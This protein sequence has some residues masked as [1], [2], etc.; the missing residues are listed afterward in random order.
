[1][2]LKTKMGCAEAAPPFCVARPKA[3]PIFYGKGIIF[4]T[5]WYIFYDFWLL[6]HRT[7]ISC[8]GLFEYFSKLPKMCPQTSCRGLLLFPD[9]PCCTAIHHYK[10]KQFKPIGF[11]GTPQRWLILQLLK[12]FSSRIDVFFSSKWLKIDSYCINFARRVWWAWS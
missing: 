7:A 10:G 4:I 9:I 6:G 12:R 11:G 1:M 2:K 8:R 3:A 5:F